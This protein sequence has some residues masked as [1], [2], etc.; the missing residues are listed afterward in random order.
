MKL[1]NFFKNLS[2]TIAKGIG[3][4][5]INIAFLLAVSAGTFSALAAIG[6]ICSLFGF[7]LHT[8][9]PH[10]FADEYAFT[11]YM[12]ILSILVVGLAGRG[13][14]FAIKKIKNIWENS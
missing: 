2:K 5:F 7:L 12:F 11:G 4:L 6:Y 1:F 3:Y 10:Y 14:Y 13:I 9:E 8:K